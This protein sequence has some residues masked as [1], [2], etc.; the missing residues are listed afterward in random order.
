MKKTV[1][2]LLFAMF[3]LSLLGQDKPLWIESDIRSAK[4]PR[5]TFITGFAEGDINAGETAEKAIERIKTAA[6]SSLLENIRVNMT[7]KTSSKTGSLS[8][9]RGYDEYE[10]FI[11]SSE[12]SAKAEIV[13]MNVESYIDKKSNYIYAFAY[14]NKYE[15]ASYY[16]ANIS[17]LI[18]QAQSALHTAEELEQNREK[19]KARKQCENVIPVLEQLRY[20]QYLLTAIDAADSEGLQQ[21]QVE[22]L[23]NSIMQM[24]A[25]LAQA[26]YVYVQSREDFFGE[27][28]SIIANRLKAELAKN[29]C[30]FV[31]DKT[32]ADFIVNINALMRVASN[33]DNMVFCYADTEYELYDNHKKKT[34]FADEISQKGGSNTEEKAARKAADNAAIAINEKIKAW[35]KQ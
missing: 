30:S 10:E 6:Q 31:D 25:R 17:M 26:V 24:Q 16:K 22:T 11:S 4:F 5:E 14:V 28:S 7:S 33:T 2:S 21:T 3:Y 35:I 29:G 8:S 32:Q 27:A 9:N 20:A 23:R 34:V 1:F 15:L 13:G 18:K 19:A 12:K